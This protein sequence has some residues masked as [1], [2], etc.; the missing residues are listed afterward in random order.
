MTFGIVS[1]RGFRFQSTVLDSGNCSIRII[2]VPVERREFKRTMFKGK[3]SK[4][5][6][7]DE[8]KKRILQIFPYYFP[9]DVPDNGG[10]V[11]RAAVTLISGLADSSFETYVLVPKKNSAYDQAFLEAGGK[12]ILDLGDAQHLV[13][14]FSRIR[15]KT[16]L[17]QYGLRLWR[18]VVKIRRL[19]REHD[20]QLVH[21]H[22]SSFLGGAIAARISGVPNVIHVH[23]YGFRLSALANRF[24][25][26]V[27]PRLADRIATCAEFIRQGFISNGSSLASVKTIYNGV[28]LDYFSTKAIEP[29]GAFMEELNVD[30]DTWLVGFVGRFTERKGVDIFVN[31]AIKVLKVRTDVVFV[32]IGGADDHVREEREYKESVI[33][34][35]RASGFTDKFRF[36]GGR[37]DMPAVYGILDLLVFCSPQDM[38][39]LVPLEAMAMGTPVVVASEGGAREEV[40]DGVTGVIVD[41]GKTDDICGTILDLMNSRTKVV[42][43]SANTREHVENQFSQERYVS[44]F[45]RL[46]DELLG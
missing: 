45:S 32:V 9:P 33:G 22:A 4:K 7:A 40:N 42:D 28:D 3:S 12:N 37:T 35:V 2:G 13:L 17:I 44:E 38:G 39:P 6:M 26:S 15:E 25:Y 30:S 16:Y 19:I 34:E 27:V 29:R 23:E 41:S 24:Y 5:H 1:T 14:E 43:M 46:Y 20:I 21:S 18:S 10:G 8:N 11:K 36:V 31:S